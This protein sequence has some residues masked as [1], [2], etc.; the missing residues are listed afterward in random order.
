MVSE[1]RKKALGTIKLPVY[2][3]VMDNRNEFAHN[4]RG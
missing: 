3:P 4:Y 2:T 1:V